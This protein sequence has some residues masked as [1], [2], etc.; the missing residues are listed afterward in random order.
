M[1]CVFKKKKKKKKKIL[2]YLDDI[3]KPRLQKNP[4]DPLCPR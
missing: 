1:L 2:I 3:A 4:P